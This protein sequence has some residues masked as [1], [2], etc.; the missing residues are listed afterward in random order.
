LLFHFTYFFIV[1]FSNNKKFR[2]TAAFFADSQTNILASFRKMFTKRNSLKTF[3]AQY[4]LPWLGVALV[5]G[6]GGH[7]GGAP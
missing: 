5:V 2:S 1:A 4:D 6:Q 3:W 7:V